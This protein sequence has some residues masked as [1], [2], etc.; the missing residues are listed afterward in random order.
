MTLNNAIDADSIIFDL[1]GTLWNSTDVV[2]KAW[3]ETI[4]RHEEVR[5]P[6][7]EEILQSFMG[8]QLHEIGEKFLGYL[9]EKLRMKILKECCKLENEVLRKEGGRLYPD[10]ENTLKLL[11]ESY[12]LFI[13]SNCQ[14]GYIEAFLESHGMG[15]LFKD[16]E[17]PGYTGLPKADNIKLIVQR[18]NLKKPIYV[19]D[20]QGD[21]NSAAK[22]GVPFVYAKYGFG[23]VESYDYYIDNVKDII[24]LLL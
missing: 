8:L 2:I 12:P 16:F 17:C 21:C 24:D 18:N 22:A 5:E 6:I 3:K 13:V 4:D 9:D 10:L 15:G 19:G 1:D 14:D 20:T 11:S 7:S 23:N